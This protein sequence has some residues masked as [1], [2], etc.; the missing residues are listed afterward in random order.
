ME[1]RLTHAQLSKIVGEVERLSQQQQDE[2]SPEQVKAILQELN[3]PPELL[4]EA[5]VQLQRREALEVQQQR[6]RSIIMGVV[7]TIVVVGTSIVLFSQQHQQTLAQVSANRDR[8]TLESDRS[9]DI[10]SVS[11]QATPQLAYQVTLQNA[12]VNKKLTLSCDWISP[13]GETI[14]QNHYETQP[15]QTP[16]WDTY[17]RY[18]LNAD[19]PPGIWQVKMFLQGR[20]LSNASFE[21]K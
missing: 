21:V 3:L 7:A 9:Q 14:K 2:L 12:P 18:Q 20:T 16:V 8:V 11:R 10:R 5:M 4:D 15:I 17:C 1:P 19:D 6:N 13:T